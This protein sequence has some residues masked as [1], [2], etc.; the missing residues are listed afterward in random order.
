MCGVSLK[1]LMGKIT[2]QNSGFHFIQLERDYL[3]Y[4]TYV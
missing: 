1:R 3:F 4:Y 2:L